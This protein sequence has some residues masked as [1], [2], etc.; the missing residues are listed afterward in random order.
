MAACGRASIPSET[1][2]LVDR[3]VAD[4]ALECSGV[5]GLWSGLVL[6]C[7]LALVKR[8]PLD[9]RFFLVGGVQTA[10]LLAMN[11][12]PVA[13]GGCRGMGGVEVASRRNGMTVDLSRERWV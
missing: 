8:Q 3:G 10:V 2:L 11:V 4:V 1:V 6:L 13:A 12:L 7:V 9:A 5:R